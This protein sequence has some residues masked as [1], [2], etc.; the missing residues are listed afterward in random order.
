MKR[1]DFLRPGT[2]AMSVPAIAEP[3]WAFD[4][5][6]RP[7]GGLFCFRMIAGLRARGADTKHNGINGIAPFA[8]VQ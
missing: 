1:R 4:Y 5:P 7:P 8:A 6:V 3:A 2:G